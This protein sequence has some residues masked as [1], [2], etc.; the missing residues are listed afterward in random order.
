MNA[1]R[2]LSGMTSDGTWV[3]KPYVGS[4]PWR[5]GYQADHVV[6]LTSPNGDR[7]A[8]VWGTFFEDFTVLYAEVAPERRRSGVYTR[9]LASMQQQM[10]VYSDED[11]NNSAASAYRR[12]GAGRAPTEHRYRLRRQEA[13][14]VVEELLEARHLALSRPNRHWGV[15]PSPR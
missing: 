9:L 7:V 2:G 11:A 10:T 3:L 13:I 12:L 1:S 14:R 4:T 8:T 15:H 5:S 6:Q